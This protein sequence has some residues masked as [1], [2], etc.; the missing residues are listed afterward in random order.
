MKEISITINESDITERILS[1]SGYAALAR[2]KAGLPQ[3]FTDMM[4]TTDDDLGM[5]Q[6]FVTESIDEAT[7]II[8]RYLSPATASYVETGKAG[9]RLIRI[10]FTLPHNYPACTLESLGRN[11]GSF[12]TSR[13]LQQWMLTVKPDEAQLHAS[14]ADTSLA[15]IRSLLSARERPRKEPDNKNNIIEL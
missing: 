13:S 15:R 3:Q 10:A 6:R 14:M 9:E 11:I 4:Q 7:G 12:A 2:T 5:V 1:M 8:S